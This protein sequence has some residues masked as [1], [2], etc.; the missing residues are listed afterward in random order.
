MAVDL[1]SLPAVAVLRLFSIA[2]SGWRPHAIET[3]LVEEGVACDRGIPLH[4]VAD[5]REEH[6][7]RVRLARA[8]VFPVLQL[9]AVPLVALGSVRDDVPQVIR[10]GSRHS[11]RFEDT[12]GHELAVG[13]A[14]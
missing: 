14:G 10:A 13:L 3:L 9:L 8:D 5:A 11:E 1:R 2:Q 12:L 6:P 4:Q 7:G